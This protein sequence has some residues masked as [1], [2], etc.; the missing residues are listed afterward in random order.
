MQ[1]PTAMSGAF[2]AM[3]SLKVEAGARYGPEK[4]TP[5]KIVDPDFQRESLRISVERSAERVVR[6][7]TA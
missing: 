2:S 4:K 1:P 7:V 5:S 3:S 6:L